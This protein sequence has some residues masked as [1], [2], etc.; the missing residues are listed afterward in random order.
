MKLKTSFFDFAVL[1]KDLIRFW[2]AWGLYLIGGLLITQSGMGGDPWYLAGDLGSSLGTMGIINALYAALI[3]LLL[4]GDLFKAKMCN[5]LH[6]LPVRRE[7]WFVTHVIA[8][9]L[10]CLVPNLVLALL[11]MPYGAQFWYVP[12]LWLS[13]VLMQYLFYFGGAVFSIYLTGNGFA[14][15]LVYALINFCSILAMW[16]VD[17][18]YTPLLYG[19]KTNTSA[20]TK[21]SPVVH[22]GEEYEL[23]DVA[24]LETC[25]NLYHDEYTVYSRQCQYKLVHVQSQWVYLAIIAAI[26]VALLA[27][28]LLLYRRRKLESAGDFAAIRPMKTIFT[29]VGSIAAGMLFYVFHDN[30]DV[31]GY[32]LLL[33][34]GIVGFFVCQMLLMRTIKVFGKKNWGKLGILVATIALSIGLTAVDVLG[35]TRIVPD[36]DD[37]VSVTIAEDHLSDYRLEQL[38]EELAAQSKTRGVD[39]GYMMGSNGYLTLTD[40]AQIEEAIAIHELLLQ[41]GDPADDYYRKNYTAVTVHYR[42]K[43]GTTLTR[44]YYGLSSGEAIKRLKNF[45]NTPAYILGVTSPEELLVN[46]KA[47]YYSDDTFYRDVREADWLQKLAAALY[48]DADAG[49]L[50]QDR[51]DSKAYV[52]FSY[53]YPDGRYSY[54]SFQVPVSATNTQAWA[55]EYCAYLIK[56]GKLTQ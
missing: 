15:G 36:A 50:N 20:F 46:L 47:V 17:A 34:G 48:A 22:L 21:F 2:P 43:N 19:L 11:L 27:A 10:M 5:A 25:T 31:L 56:N 37:V 23:W 55:E 6:A 14:A 7:A 35:L 33:L 39:P 4:F 18:F 3:A 44:Y 45:T 28:S 54:L 8:G 13:M 42:L 53:E 49:N 29:V 12:L 41:E 24:H 52:E 40:P 32:I 51:Y 16:F 26:G 9:I 38:E 30:D 1:K